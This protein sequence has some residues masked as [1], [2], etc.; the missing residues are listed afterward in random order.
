MYCD[1]DFRR[2]LMFEFSGVRC[3]VGIRVWRSFVSIISSFLRR[4]WVSC[5]V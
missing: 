4:T 1:C 2:I 3:G 5:L